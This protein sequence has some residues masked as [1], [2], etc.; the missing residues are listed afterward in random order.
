M[1]RARGRKLTVEEAVCLDGVV[2]H[3]TGV[4]AAPFGTSYTY[5]WRRTGGKPKGSI[6]YKVMEWP[7]CV[8]A[9]RLSYEVSNDRSPTK[10]ELDY[11]VK[12]TAT[13]CAFGGRRMW[14]VCP[15]SRNGIPCGRRALRLYLADGA[16]FGCRE[17]LGLTYMSCQQS[18]K[19]VYALARSPELL[20]MALRIGTLRQRLLAVSAVA[21][22]IKRANRQSARRKMS[23]SDF[24][25]RGRYGK[26]T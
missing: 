22:L 20:R 5:S 10:Q 1:G 11:I 8:L 9:L 19:R 24:I 21:L 14:L 25:Q 13:R 15:L 2:L 23:K 3:R 26:Q 18:D 6:T 7:G 16:V 12:V 4:F 17:C